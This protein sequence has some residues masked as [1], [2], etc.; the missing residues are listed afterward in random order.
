[1]TRLTFSNPGC[2]STGGH[3]QS[4]NTNHETKLE[5]AAP[6]IRA[7]QR[8]AWVLI[9]LPSLAL[10]ALNVMTLA[11]GYSN[12]APSDLVA[13]GVTA[14]TP[15]STIALLNY[16]ARG[17]AGGSLIF[18]VL[19][20]I[21]ACTSYRTGARWAWYVEFYLFVATFAAG[22]ME[23]IEEGAI[24]YSQNNIIAF[25]IFS[26]PFALGLILPYRR[27][28]LTNRLL[29]AVLVVLLLSGIVI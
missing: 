7:Y 16:I 19:A 25:L 14:S 1:M 13:A 21:V 18:V 26:L 24:S 29:V 8:Y 22:V 5:M 28:F 15:P 23:T 27:F 2:R 10:G 4:I 12:G 17:A 6:P 9:L 3:L 11:V 20:T